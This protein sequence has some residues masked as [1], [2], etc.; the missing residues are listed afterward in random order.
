MKSIENRTSDIMLKRFLLLCLTVLFLSGCIKSGHV[1][2]RGL[3]LEDGFHPLKDG[4]KN[5]LLLG[6]DTEGSLS[7]EREPGAAGQSDAMYLLTCDIPG[8]RARII[9]IPRD[10]MTEIRVFLP[11][12]KDNG[13]S[14]D[15][16]TLQYAFGD[17][18]HESCK[19]TREAVSQLLCGLPID[20]YLAVNLGAIPAC[21]DLIGGV[22]VVVPDDSASAEEPSF[23][24]DS[25]VT[26]DSRNVKKFLRYRDIDVPQSAMTRMERH[27]VFFRACAKKL[28]E[29]IER[30]P[31]LVL[32]LYKACSS[33]VVTDISVEKLQRIAEMDLD[34]SIISIPGEEKEGDGY[35][36]FNVEEPALQ[37]MLDR[38]F[39][40]P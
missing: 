32:K 26:L 37:E 11:S 8:N 28:R 22:E 29:E 31:T 21:T 33:E 4:V 16:L 40:E 14:V 5:Y 20:G 1:L 9:A 10:T 18:R 15:H 2:D 25:R 6:I 23:A 27:K 24:K 34:E 7:E 13:S 19:L 36:E 30:D 17:G 35:D 12:G 3:T 39:C 38:L